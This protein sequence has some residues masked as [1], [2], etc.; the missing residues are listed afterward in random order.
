MIL[1]RTLNWFPVRASAQGSLLV[2]QSE[3]LTTSKNWWGL[4]GFPELQIT[5]S[6]KHWFRLSILPGF[7]GDSST[8]YAA[9]VLQ[10]VSIITGKSHQLHG[11]ILQNLNITLGFMNKS[12]TIY[13]HPSEIA[14]YVDNMK[15]H[16]RIV[17]ICRVWAM[18]CYNFGRRMWDLQR[19]RSR[20]VSR[21]ICIAAAPIWCIS[22]VR[23]LFPHS[24]RQVSVICGNSLSTRDL[25][26]WYFMASWASQNS[27]YK[28]DFAVGYQ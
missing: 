24:D 13:E 17:R 2:L 14:K 5:R 3:A 23:L 1:L 12:K 8:F 11:W 22:W 25:V 20:D 19:V 18:S 21:Q 16:F 4:G 15:G 7:C 28:C 9:I 26:G 27:L 6:Q 10:K